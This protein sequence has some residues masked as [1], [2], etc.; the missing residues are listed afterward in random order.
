MLQLRKLISKNKTK[1]KETKGTLLTYFFVCPVFL[2]VMQYF[3]KINENKIL[4]KLKISRLELN[5]LLK[6]KK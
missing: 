2:G 1:N 6:N 5:F 3:K 4:N